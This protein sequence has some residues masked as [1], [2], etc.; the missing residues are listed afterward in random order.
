MSGWVRS[1]GESLAA[2]LAD[3]ATWRTAVGATDAAGAR[4]QIVLGD[5]GLG[6]GVSI[7]GNFID[8]GL[9]HALIRVEQ[10]RSE[11]VGLRCYTYSGD[12]VV[13]MI[14][15]QNQALPPED[16]AARVEALAALIHELQDLVGADLSGSASALLNA[17]IT[18]DGLEL[19]SEQDE[20]PS[21]RLTL[22]VAWSQLP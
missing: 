15:P 18:A 2:M 14:V 8:P 20:T 6:H 21:W 22:V 13:Q 12:A 5:G 19:D 9:P 10:V 7:D 17:E 4:L 16:D 3:C 1:V 11:A